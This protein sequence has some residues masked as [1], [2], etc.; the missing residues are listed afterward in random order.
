MQNFA[1]FFSHQKIIEVIRNPFFLK[2]TGSLSDW[3]DGVSNSFT[4]LH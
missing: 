2:G 4:I 1:L 3:V